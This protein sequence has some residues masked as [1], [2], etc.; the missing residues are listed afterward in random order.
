[1]QKCKD[2]ELITSK[3][4]VVDRWRKFFDVFLQTIAV[5][6]FP[7]SRRSNGKLGHSRTT[8]PPARTGSRQSSINMEKRL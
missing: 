3:C 2:V 8:E 5:S 7:I 1:M 6:Q 4:D